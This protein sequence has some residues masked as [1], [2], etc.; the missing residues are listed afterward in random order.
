MIFY[1][2]KEEVLEIKLT[3]YGR[4]LLS[5][6]ELEPV[7]YSFFDDDVLYDKKHLIGK[8]EN[9]TYDHPYGWKTY[10]IDIDNEG[11]HCFMGVS[12]QENKM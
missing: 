10:A 12:Y 1:D 7:Y 8:E 5:L 4:Y 6:G 2:R 9:I 11:V 3:P